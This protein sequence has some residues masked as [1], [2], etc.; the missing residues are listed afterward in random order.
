MSKSIH[1][2]QIHQKNEKGPFDIIGDIHGCFDELHLLLVQLGY[3]ISKKGSYQI[4]HPDNRK[5][6]FVGDLVDR[7]PRSP[8]VL[9][10][11]MD[12]VTSRV[13][14]CVV[15]NH[16][17]KL[18]KQLMGRNV[19]IAH[20]LKETLEQME[21]E[22]D[23]FKDDVIHFIESLP[24]HIIFDEGRL[25]VAHA[26][27]KEEYIGQDSLRVR[28]FCMYG[29][30]TGDVDENGLPVR[31]PWQNDY[32]GNTMIVYGHTPI[33]KPEWT[34]NT[35]NLDTGCVFGGRL[36]ALRYP[37][38]ELISVKAAKVYY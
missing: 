34:G 24:C 15:G 35:I 36:T 21:K 28:S 30:S 12:T 26:G 7:G 13:G 4:S 9:K 22:S 37:E 17:D 31:Y 18:K 10:L 2:Q 32:Q 23:E 19:V 3:S 16:D 8:D 29:E 6:V 1:S 20:G 25:A 5:L 27:I 11:V 33:S 38:K 14:F